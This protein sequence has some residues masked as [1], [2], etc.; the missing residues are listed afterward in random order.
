MR[1]LLTF[2][3][4]QLVSGETGF[5]FRSLCVKNSQTSEANI[6]TISVP[7]VLAVHGI[8]Y[9]PEESLMNISHSALLQGSYQVQNFPT[10]H[11]NG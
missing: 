10:F 7:R 2:R 11:L 5:E 4:S 9:K 1:E 8:Y 3:S 6:L